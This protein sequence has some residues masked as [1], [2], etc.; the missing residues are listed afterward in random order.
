M[1]IETMT[2][3]IGQLGFPIAAF[4]MCAFLLYQNMRQRVE[5][6]KAWTKALENNTA[7]MERVVDR[8]DRL[9]EYH[10]GA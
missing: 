1:E 6:S 7:V 8:L 4:C 9:E 2:A 3:L 10:R 5:D